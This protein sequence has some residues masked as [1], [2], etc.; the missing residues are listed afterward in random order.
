MAA[1]AKTRD[2]YS[3]AEDSTPSTSAIVVADDDPGFR[4]AVADT[5]RDNGFD[6]IEAADGTMLVAILRRTKL[7]LVITDVAMPW[8]SGT[9]VI[10]MM[11][12]IGDTTPF[13]VITGM[14]DHLREQ[15][16]R[17][18]GVAM[19][20]KPIGVD[21]LLDAVRDAIGLQDRSRRVRGVASSVD[22]THLAQDRMP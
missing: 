13:L 3:P 7:S 5:L 6:V 2:A 15:A 10:E 17:W 9:D 16:R 20:E 18:H 14:P 8:L 19:I 4:V 21:A 1:S 11:R 22:P 12:S